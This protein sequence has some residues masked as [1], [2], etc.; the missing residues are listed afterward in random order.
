MT[1]IAQVKPGDNLLVNGKF[2][3]DQEDFPPFWANQASRYLSYNPSGGPNGLPSVK[4]ASAE[5]S[6][7]E[8]T[9]RQYD[10]ELVAGEIYR[11]S[12]WVRTKDFKSKHYGI[13]VCNNGWFSEQGIKTFAPTQDWTLMTNEFKAEKSNNGKHMMIFF[14]VN[15][16]GEVEIADV[17][18]EAISKG[19]LEGSHRPQISSLLMS[20]QLIP[21]APLLNQIPLSKPELTFRYFGKLPEGTFDDYW[22]ILYFDDN[23]ALR[24]QLQ[25][26]LNT[27]KLPSQAGKHRISVEIVP[28]NAPLPIWKEE[29]GITIVDIPKVSSEGHR[30]LNNLVTEILNAELAKDAAEQTFT[31]SHVRNGWVYFAR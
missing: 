4:L 27:A 15:F 17:K 14:A 28:K 24:Q 6:N 11:V 3:A 26:G 20:P 25:R 21:T 30:R 5:P 22:F 31:V 13:T 23:A 8:S 7:T 16:Q 12:A 9:F 18:L 2:D 19:A 1:A 29:F 10:L